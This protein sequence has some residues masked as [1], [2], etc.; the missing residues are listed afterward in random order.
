MHGGAVDF[1]LMNAQHVVAVE[2]GFGSWKQ[3]I[4][5]PE[6]EL[7]AAIMRDKAPEWAKQIQAVL[8]QHPHLTIQGFR[9][10]NLSA[11]RVEPH[12]TPEAIREGRAAFFTA[13]GLAQVQAA[14]AYLDQIKPARVSTA[15]SPGSYGLK[16]HAERW[17]ERRRTDGGHTY[18]SNGGLIM[19]A[20]IKGLT[21][22]R[23]DERSPNCLIGVNPREVK[24]LSEGIDPATLRVPASPFV[25]W[26]YKQA[27]REDPVG[28]LA[29]DA[30]DDL[31]FPRGGLEEVREY[32]SRYGGHVQDA[33]E[34]A[35]AE[36]QRSA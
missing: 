26:L 5:A 2:A 4:A 21:I 7:Q 13:D 33:L 35:S 6:G 8:D 32:L 3:L 25:R 30:K 1:R 31:H 27:G 14:K 22:K 29:S 16:H 20:L 24:A 12:R 17:H 10:P 9:E 18:V 23:E 28:D 15:K 11:W 34:D 36:W 19:A